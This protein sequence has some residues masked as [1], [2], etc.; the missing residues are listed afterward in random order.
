MVRMLLIFLLYLY[1]ITP[2]DVTDLS[3]GSLYAKQ[4]RDPLS[5]IKCR[6]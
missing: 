1:A 5:V 4:W 2:I 3:A 6:S